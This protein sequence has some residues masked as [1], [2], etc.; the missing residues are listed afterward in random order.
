MTRIVRWLPTLATTA[1][2]S[3]ALLTMGSRRKASA[4]SDSA[5]TVCTL[6]SVMT[7]GADLFA[8]NGDGFV[9]QPLVNVGNFT[10]C[11]LGV[12]A[13]VWTYGQMRFVQWDP[14]TLAPDPT[15]VAL[16]TRDFSPSDLLYYNNRARADFPTAI[17][18]RTIPRVAEP[19][20]PHVAMQFLRDDPFSNGPLVRYQPNGTTAYPP[21]QQVRPAGTRVPLPGPHPVA[22]IGLCTGGP[23]TQELRVV[24]SVMRTDVLTD[25]SAFEFAQRFRVPAATTLRWV[26]LAGAGYQYRWP[27][28]YGNISILEGQNLPTLPTQ[29]PAA[30]VGAPFLAYFGDDAFWS[31]H[32]AFDHTI[33]LLPDHDY[34]LVA[35]LDHD[36]TVYLRQRTGAEG[37]DFVRDIGPLFQRTEPTASFTEL[38]QH[39]LAFRLIGEP[40]LPVDAGSPLVRT[41]MLRLAASP[42]PARGPVTL[43]WSGA[44][45]RLSIDVLD[46]RGRRVQ[47]VDLSTV[48]AGQWQFLGADAS[49]RPL[50]AGLYFVRATD[51]A[52]QRALERV[53]IVR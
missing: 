20:G 38:P 26:E 51:S 39:T 13:P 9:E 14:T 23:E 12:E 32:M 37:G 29:L 49:G 41:P 18:T 34:W 1:L 43:A 36:G 6:T 53:V 3:L 28:E 40:I 42:N 33:A 44:R 15:T 47:Q 11:S 7:G 35:R 2:L 4:T 24:Q 31:S 48:G 22:S 19:P 21:A 52:G 30:M 10:A 5:T 27:L 8:A 17:V 45:G 50:P 46:A 16:R 25:T